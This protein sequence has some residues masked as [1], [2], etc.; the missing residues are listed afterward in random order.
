MLTTLCSY[1]DGIA[2]GWESISHDDD[3]LGASRKSQPQI[4]LTTAAGSI[5]SS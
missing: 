4:I 3:A 2:E 1:E 5:E